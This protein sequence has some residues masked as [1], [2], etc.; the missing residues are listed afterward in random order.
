MYIALNMTSEGMNGD[1]EKKLLL[2]T[3]ITLL[4]NLIFK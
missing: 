1:Y 2:H 3:I 4:L